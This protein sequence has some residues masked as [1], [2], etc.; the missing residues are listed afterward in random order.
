MSL[1]KP[2]TLGMLLISCL[3]LAY[4]QVGVGGELERLVSN[5][6][7]RRPAGSNSLKNYWQTHDTSSAAVMPVA[8]SPRGET[9]AVMLKAYQGDLD[10]LRSEYRGV[11]QLPDVHFFL[12]GMGPRRK[13][14]YM[15]GRLRDAL[16]GETI[17]KWDLAEEIIVP[18]AYEVLIKTR[19]GRS[20][21]V[22]EDEEG[23]WLVEGD[24]R[25]ALS[26]S[27]L[28]LPTFAGNR[29][30]AILRVLHQEVLINVIDG[31]PVPNYFVYSK[32]WYRDGAMMGMVLKETG[33]LSLIKDW[34]LG[35]REP[36]DRNNAGE[37]EADN[38]GQVLYLVSL[39]SDKSHPIVRKTRDCFSH[40]KTDHYINGRS[41]FAF[42]PVYQT[43]WA[44][45]GL[46]ALGIDDPY[47]VPLVKD[48]YSSLF[49][50]D[51]RD[52]Y[53]RCERFDRGS[54]ENYPYLVW[55]EDHFYGEKRG[56][57]GNRDYPL[58][59]EANASQADYKRMKRISPLYSEQKLSV[60]H[61]WH[62]AEMFLRL[63][64]AR[65]Q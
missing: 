3:I 7:P 62:A 37:T 13:M 28:R 43:K 36:F 32:P 30:A 34:I 45:Y 58:S 2:M 16:T 38:L 4:R 24:S 60:P 44:K 23:V 22:M 47:E 5:N 15:D 39:V 8:L 20:I 35:L 11:R 14:I 49:W 10:R 61:T 27:R 19:E 21:K 33:N 50:W 1:F 41:D 46:K 57:L 53:V 40:F 54:A 25:T 42:H 51:Y 63:L 12:F 26:Q 29:F 52:K 18:P 17:R 59:W 55:A 56:P 6:G 9:P 31:K 65:P 48:S 64:E